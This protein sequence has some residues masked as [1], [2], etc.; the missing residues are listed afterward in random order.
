MRVPLP[1]AMMTTSTALANLTLSNLELMTHSLWQSPRFLKLPAI[2]GWALALLLA[3]ALPGCSAVKLGYNNAPEIS[4]WWLDGYLDFDSSQST[5]VRKELNTV[6][7]WHRQSELPAY[8]KTLEKVQKM[9]S[10]TIT[11]AQ[12]CEVYAEVKPRFQLIVDQTEP[13]INSM[14]PTLKP[15]QIVHL[16]RQ[17]EKRSEKW[18]E[19]WLDGSVAERR[20]RRVKQWRDRTEMLYG[21]LDEAQLTLLRSQVAESSFDA[22]AS[23]RESQRRHQDTLQTLRKI[24]A[25]KSDGAKIKSDIRGLLERSMTSPDAAYRAQMEKLTL[26]NCKTVATLHNSTTA[27]QRQKAKS[28]L[29]G[30]ATDAL[31]LTLQR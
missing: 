27:A 1:A 21:R 18:R 4:Y 14:A 22:A 30:Y 13:L 26:E 12:V 29:E 28:V 10:G 17:L 20:E 5:Q 9:T 8:V 15:E 11:P 7:A 6:Q 3:L 2:I 25:D 31:T 16:S 24:Q 19:E 23:Y